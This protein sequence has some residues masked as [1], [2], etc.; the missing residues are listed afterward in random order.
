M[1][2]G[3]TGTGKVLRLDV[4]GMEV[5]DETHS[6]RQVNPKKLEITEVENSALDVIETNERILSI[7]VAFR[8][9]ICITT[10]DIQVFQKGKILF[11]FLIF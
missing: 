8:H 6:L 10:Q 1:A 11:F 4:G 2:L 7:S 9:I 5:E 3:A